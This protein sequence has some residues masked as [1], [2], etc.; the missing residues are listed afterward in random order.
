MSL[1][2]R[3]VSVLKNFPHFFIYIY[4]CL[5]IKNYFASYNNLWNWSLWNEL[6]IHDFFIE[7]VKKSHLIEVLM[8]FIKSPWNV[9][10]CVFVWPALDSR[11][12]ESLNHTD[13]HETVKT[14]EAN[15][16]CRSNVFVM[17]TR[18]NEFQKDKARVGSLPSSNFEWRTLHV[19]LKAID[20]R[21]YWADNL[22]DKQCCG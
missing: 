7:L 21:A 17:S 10:T 22:P 14:R 15:G 9:C 8:K 11:M 6:T 20:R 5:I 13:I 12:T 18:Y 3:Q 2:L 4:T 19:T 16:V 1:F